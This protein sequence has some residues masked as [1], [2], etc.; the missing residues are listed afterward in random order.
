V[1]DREKCEVATENKMEDKNMSYDSQTDAVTGQLNDL[2]TAIQGVQTQAANVQAAATAIGMANTAEAV[3]YVSPALA[4]V[5][6]NLQVVE[7]TLK[8][9]KGSV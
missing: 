3:G 7:N 9:V 1:R 2:I 6:S 4:S 8:D 5:L